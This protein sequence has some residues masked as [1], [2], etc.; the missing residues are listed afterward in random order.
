MA[1]ATQDLNQIMISAVQARIESEVAAAMAG[2]EFVGRL[3]TAALMQPVEVQDP[4]SM[5]GKIKVPFLTDVLNKTIQAATKNAVV[6]LISEQEDEIEQ[7]VRKELK[8]S[9]AEIAKQLVGSVR[10]ATQDSYGVKV[11]LQFPGR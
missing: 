2:D 7:A 4:R 6:R 9:T 11:E 5:Y 8:A 1:D 3:V 10:K